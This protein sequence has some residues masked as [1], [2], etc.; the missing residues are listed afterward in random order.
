[1][2]P[3]AADAE[4]FHGCGKRGKEV[5]SRSLSVFLHVEFSAGVPPWLRPSRRFST[6][7]GHGAQRDRARG[8]SALSVKLESILQYLDDYL[9]IAGH[10]DYPVALNGLQV[11]GAAEVEVVCTAVDSSESAIDAAAGRGAQL[12]VVHHGLFWDGLKPIVGRRRRKLV[13]LLRA[14]LALYSAHLPLDS[15]PEVGNCALLL[16]SLGIEP[17]G[18]FASYQGT[19]IG[20][21]GEADSSRPDLVDRLTAALGGPVQTHGAGPVRVRRVGVVTGSGATF[22]DAA[23]KCGID[24]L[25]TGEGPH[26]AAIDA[27]ELGMNLLY[28]GHYATETFGVRALGEMLVERFGVQHQFLDLPTGT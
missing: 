20:W 6:V 11:E 17:K 27:T 24:T 25:V 16:R 1:M 21:W 26:H 4:L 28:G 9:G 7:G 19:E 22:L 8:K 2:F 15:H 10:P 14:N 12:L 3:A 23:A 5:E 13:R 18:R